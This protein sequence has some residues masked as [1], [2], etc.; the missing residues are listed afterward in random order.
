MKRRLFVAGVA[1]GSM[2]SLAGCLSSSDDGGELRGEYTGDPAKQFEDGCHRGE[3][4][5]DQVRLS[6]TLS[7]RVIGPSSATWRIDIEAGT[8]LIISLSVRNP[9][10]VTPKPPTVEFIGPDGSGPAGPN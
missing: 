7:S 10:E 3:I 2:G 1:A 5:D 4:V 6:G 8:H 9:R